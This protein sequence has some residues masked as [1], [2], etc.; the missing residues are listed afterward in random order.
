MVNESDFG[1]LNTSTSRTP[2][3]GYD[4][5][6]TFI[7]PPLYWALP[8]T[9]RYA[10]PSY[11]LRSARTVTVAILNRGSV[12][13]NPKKYFDCRS[14]GDIRSARAATAAPRPASAT[15]ANSRVPDEP[16]DV[17]VILPTSS[18]YVLSPRRC[19]H[20]RGT[21]PGRPNVR[22][23]SLPL[24]AATTPRTASS[25]MGL[26]SSSMPFTTSCT[27][28]SPPTAT[29]NRPPLRSA[30]RA[31]RIASP[32]PSVRASRY[33]RPRDCRLRSSS[34]ISS[35]TC[36]RPACGLTR[37]V[38][39]PK[40]D[41]IRREILFGFR[42]GL[43]SRVR[44]RFLSP[45]TPPPLDTGVR[46]D[47]PVDSLAR[48]PSHVGLLPLRDVLDLPEEVEQLLAV[49]HEVTGRHPGLAERRLQGLT[50]GPPVHGRGEPVVELP[51][52]LDVVRVLGAP[53]APVDPCQPGVALDRR[54]G[55]ELALSRNA[56]PRLVHDRRHERG[57]LGGRESFEQ[58][59]G[60]KLG[61]QDVTFSV[62]PSERATLGQDREV[63]HVPQFREHGEDA[64]ELP[65]ERFGARLD[66]PLDPPALRLQFARPPRPALVRRAIRTGMAGMLLRLPFEPCGLPLDASVDTTA[67][68]ARR[69]DVERHEAR[70][71]VA[72][73]PSAP[74]A[75]RP[76]QRYARQRYRRLLE[77][78]WRHAEELPVLREHGQPTVAV[79]E[80]RGEPA[81]LRPGHEDHVAGSQLPERLS[82]RV[83]ARSIA[84]L[85][86]VLS[87]PLGPFAQAPVLLEVASVAPHLLAI[88]RE[89][90]PVALQLSLEGH[91][92]PVGQEL[93]ER[94]VQQVVRFL[95]HV[96][97]HEVHG[98]VVRGSKRRCELVGPS[99]GERRHALERHVP[100]EHHDGVAELVDAAA[101]RA[102]RQLRVLTRCEQLVTLALELPQVLDHDRLRGHVDA[103]RQRLGSEHDPDQTGLEKLL[104]GLLEHRKHPG[105]VRRDPGGERV[106]ELVEAERLEVLLVHPRGPHLGELADAPGLLVCRQSDARGHEPLDAPIAPRPT[107]H[108]VDRREHRALGEHVGDLLALGDVDAAMAF[109]RTRDPVVLQGRRTTPIV[110]LVS[111]LLAVERDEVRVRHRLPVLVDVHRVQVVAHQVV[112]LE[113]DRSSLLDDHAGRAAERSDPLAELLCVGDRRRQT[114]DRDRQRKVDQDLLPY[115]AAVRVLEVVHLVHHHR[116]Q[117]V[118]RVASLV[119]HVPQ[120]LGGHDDDGRLTVDRVVPGEQAHLRGAVSGDQV[121]ELLVRE[122][123]QRRRVEA[124]AL[125]LEC[126]LDR[127]LGDDR[128]A[129]A[130]RRGHEHRFPL[131]ERLDRR[132]LE[133]VERKW[134]PR[135]EALRIGHLCGWHASTLLRVTDRVYGRAPR[136]P[137]RGIVRRGRRRGRAGEATGRTRPAPRDSTGVPRRR[138]R[139]ARRRRSPLPSPTTRRVG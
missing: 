113:G 23:K 27:V 126:A 17:Y 133:R 69:P 115:G 43:R 96:V 116:D 51:D 98:H 74:R 114:H 93:R 77:I 76:R 24:P 55:G 100:L 60:Q 136:R 12:S 56:L 66:P 120:H 92:S 8:T 86:G 139:E 109:T 5:G 73:V 119:Q 117:A 127:V 67:R 13:Q 90:G 18:G 128:L 104:D 82:N 39:S 91:D 138:A 137:G 42:R 121:A 101:S 71:E 112:V 122:R 59:V 125:F 45:P 108:E 57:G 3:P 6:E 47:A 25:T 52:Q 48:L 28:P 134:V 72:A 38:S 105:M 78:P 50:F 35:P 2:S 61:D 21:S 111:D 4:R 32:R 132:E 53:N 22:M 64:F 65:G 129:G 46:H 37:T 62:D 123:L 130:G 9:I 68:P 88:A 124:L 16:F 15:L 118:Q 33:G 54:G 106:L 41:A 70:G 110:R 63:L 102:T 135:R 85:P 26:P 49:P 94:R 83:D 10:G 30:S 99:R 97:P 89:V 36:R 81:A 31:R 44:A 107:E 19:W 14:R 1:P 84:S 131:R 34:G 20:A 79:R 103:E 7:P 11:D 75:P 87:D 95:A 58:P 40:G 80:H 29:M